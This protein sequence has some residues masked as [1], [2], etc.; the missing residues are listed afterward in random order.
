M[1]AARAGEAHE[2][3]DADLMAAAKESGADIK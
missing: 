2:P 1:T 3:S